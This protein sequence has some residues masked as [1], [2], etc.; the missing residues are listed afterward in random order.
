MP[1]RKKKKSM[2]SVGITGGIGSGKSTICYIFECLGVPVYYADDAAKKLMTKKGALK[3]RITALFGKEAYF[4]NGKLNRKHIS[5][6]AFPNP[7]LLKHLNAAVHP[8][9]IEDGKKWMDQR[10]MEGH[11]YAIKEAALLIESGSYTSLDKIIVVS[12]PLEIR[13]E[14]AMKRDKSSAEKIKMRIDAQMPDAEREKF[15]DYIISN[16]GQR[17]LIEQVMGVHKMLMMPV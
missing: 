10:A 1:F 17:S 4:K 14:R 7:E 3:D 16:D 5:A 2:L 8:A 9:V 11:P 12:C 6:M 15:A 13:L